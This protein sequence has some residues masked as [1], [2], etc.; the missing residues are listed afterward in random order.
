MTAKPLHFPSRYTGPTVADVGERAVTLAIQ[1]MAPSSR[2]GDDAAVLATPAPNTR[3]VVST[4]VLVEGRHFSLNWSSAEEVGRKAIVQNFADI[5]AMGARPVA[6]L[7]GL[8][9]PGHTPLNFV[10]RLIA[11]MWDKTL[12]HNSELVG[13][14]LTRADT[15]IVSITAIG[16][17]GG[18]SPALTLDRARAGQRLVASGPIGYS[19]AG[20]A[21]LRHHGRT[22]I[23][24]GFAPLIDAHCAPTLIPGRG[25]IARATG[26]TAMTD[27]SDGLIL[28]LT[29]MARRSNVRIDLDS[30]A[31]T[32]D[33]LL[34][35]A[36]DHLGIDPWSW[37]LTGG[38]D[39]TLL[40]TT[41][42]D[43]PSGFRTI[44]RVHRTHAAAH[45]T[46]DG[47]PPTYTAGWES[48]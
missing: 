46:M 18:S 26:A 33:S 29:T 48:F 22:G 39:H 20:L 8:T 7:L 37:V 19:A 10:Q 30:A 1:R 14:D 13:G 3:T 40:A 4:D 38:E 27:N 34:R 12:Q 45:V 28:D 43:A 11:G 2:N 21:L 36:G 17:L 5:E 23:P 41:T 35:K 44:G 16:I 25:V 24:A 6:A 47:Y 42:S 31:I 32:P 9:M 15:L